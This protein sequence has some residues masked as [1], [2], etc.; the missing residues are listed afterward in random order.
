L[1]PIRQILLE[2]GNC[3]NE[4]IEKVYQVKSSRKYLVEVTEDYKVFN[5]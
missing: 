5:Y 4:V 1:H 3:D 2:V